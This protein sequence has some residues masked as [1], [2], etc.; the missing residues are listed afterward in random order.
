M[1]EIESEL[2]E[3]GRSLGV[4]IPKRVVIHEKL[5]AGDSVKMLLVK[6]TNALKETFGCVQLKRSTEE[7]L[8]EV[9]EEGWNE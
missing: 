3:W 6:K 1:E 7:I 2:R 5:S 9:D 8:R 4:V